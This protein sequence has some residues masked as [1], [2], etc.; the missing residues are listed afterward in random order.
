MAVAFLGE[1]MAGHSTLG[2]TQHVWVAATATP[3]P[4]SLHGLG[5]GVGVGRGGSEDRD[6]TPGSQLNAQFDNVRDGGTCK[7]QGLQ[8]G[9]PVI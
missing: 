4:Q 3:H 5:V 6:L 9:T 8:D 2:D 1:G 7:R